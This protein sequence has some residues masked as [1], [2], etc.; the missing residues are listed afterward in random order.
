MATYWKEDKL[1]SWYLNGR[2]LYTHNCI[3]FISRDAALSVCVWGGD[4]GSLSWVMYAAILYIVYYQYCNML[5]SSIV[6]FNAVLNFH[7]VNV[8]VGTKDQTQ[9]NNGK[10]GGTVQ[11][12]K[13]WVGEHDLIAAESF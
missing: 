10:E 12:V 13:D 7:L 5:S 3:H 1:S 4:E 2:A 9:D 11:Q 6:C 8:E